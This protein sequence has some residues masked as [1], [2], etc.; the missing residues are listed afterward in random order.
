VATR[1]AAIEAEDGADVDG[2]HRAAE[3]V[4]VS[5]EVAQPVGSVSTHWRTG[6]CGSTASTRC[7]TSWAIRRPPQLEQK[8]LRL[9]EKGTK[10]SKP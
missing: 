2:E 4:I 10:R 3:R 8:P 9:Q 7:A 1:S 6:T 5:E